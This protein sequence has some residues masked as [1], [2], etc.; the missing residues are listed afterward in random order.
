MADDFTKTQKEK[1]LMII[2]AVSDCKGDESK[3]ISRRFNNMSK[4]YNCNFGNIIGSP[5]N[6]GIIKADIQQVE[7]DKVIMFS[8]LPYNPYFITEEQFVELKEFFD[9]IYEI[10]Q[11]NKENLKDKIKKILES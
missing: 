7:K 5:T 1:I 11:K 9:E 4:G 8:F 10:L 3:S 2:K 6:L